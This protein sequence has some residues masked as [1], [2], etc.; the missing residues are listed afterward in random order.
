MCEYPLDPLG[1]K[2]CISMAPKIWLYTGQY[3]Q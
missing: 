3:P 1:S 2:A